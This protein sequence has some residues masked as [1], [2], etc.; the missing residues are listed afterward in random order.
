MFVLPQ[1]CVCI[2]YPSFVNVFALPQSCVYY[3]SCVNVFLLPQE[4]VNVFPQL[5]ECD[6]ITSVMCLFLLSHLRDCIS[7]TSEICVFFTPVAWLCL[8][9]F[10]NVFVFLL[11]LHNYVLL[12]QSSICVLTDPLICVS[13]DPTMYILPITPVMY[14]NKAIEKNINLVGE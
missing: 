1:E 7:I 2:Y 12:P 11:Q 6:C 8:Y 4:G 13:V 9:Y 10:S 3:P 14:H 5:H